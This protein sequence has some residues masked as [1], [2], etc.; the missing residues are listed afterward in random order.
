MSSAGPQ[1]GR[2]RTSP[3]SHSGG[4]RPDIE[5]RS[6]HTPG[7]AD[8]EPAP[9][10][11]WPSVTRAR[12]SSLVLS[13]GCPHTFIMQLAAAMT[14]SRQSEPRGYVNLI[15]DP[16]PMV[17]DWG[18]SQWT[19]GRRF[20]SRADRRVLRSRRSLG[21][22]G[23]GSEFSRSRPSS[24]RLVQPLTSP[25]RNRSRRPSTRVTTFGTAPLRR[26]SKRHDRA[27][28]QHWRDSSP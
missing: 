11:D 24:D 18:R 23:A 7:R 9:I 3:Q 6:W 28:A 21:S 4:L 26:R 10:D 14:S 20:V 22:L 13:L 17:D 8:G 12:Q 5:R 19:R 2:G 25:R 27:S 16:Q 15:Q 1:R